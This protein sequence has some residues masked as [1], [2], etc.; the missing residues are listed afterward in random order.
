MNKQDCSQSPFSDIF[1]SI[2]R[3]T[4]P[5]WMLCGYYMKMVV[6]LQSKNIIRIILRYVLVIDYKTRN[7][8][9]I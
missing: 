3:V 1:G 9:N 4:H 5:Y 7:N 8:V 6:Y 2:A